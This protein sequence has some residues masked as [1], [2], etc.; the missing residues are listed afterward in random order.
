MGKMKLGTKI[1]GMVA[2]LL[3]LMVVSSSFGIIKIADVGNKIK[4]IA[5]EDIPLA[6]VMTGIATAQLKQDLLLE[7][8]MRYGNVIQ[9]NVNAGE[10]IGTALQK[11][12]EIAKK[13]DEEIRKGEQ[14]A[15]QAAK[16]ARTAAA[17]SEFEGILL[18]LRDIEKQHAE[19]ESDGLKMFE[20]IH[21]GKLDE[22]GALA[23]VLA[24]RVEKLDN[25]LD[26]ALRKI[27]KFTATAALAAEHDEVSG[28]RGMSIISII[29]IALGLVLGIF[30]T[31]SITK[32]INRIIESLRD[33]AGQVASA[34]TQ[35][36][37]ASQ[38]LAE[39]A[40]EQAASI[41][42][43]SSSLEEISSMTKQNADNANQANS[44]TQN[45]A[46]VI[47][48]ANESMGRLTT[49]MDEISAA[50]G[51]T[52]K[53]IKTIDEIAFQTNLLALN[54]AVE[55]ARAGEAGAGFAVVAGEVRNLA[56]RAADAAKGTASL[57]EG[58]VGK[59][60]AGSELVRETNEAFTEVA[61]KS[62]KTGELVAEI[63][64]ASNEQAE[65]IGQ[66]NK[67]I[68]EMDKVTQQNAAN[69]EESAS[70][71]EQ[72]SAQAEQMKGVVADLAALVGGNGKRTHNGRLST[73]NKET[74]RASS[75]KNLVAPSKT[76][77]EKHPALHASKE[78]KPTEVIPM[79]DGDFTDF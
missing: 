43:T 64:A 66:I 55:A 72:M 23:E 37:S 48:K 41:E 61:E 9:K 13:A 21:A 38:S 18:Q 25:E 34:S 6:N 11:F 32:P 73:P 57:I 58:T 59:V 47:T 56:M 74:G 3:I 17:R 5:E 69:A 27:E 49:S 67:A 10:Y 75:A 7:R 36:S 52:F 63:A 19:Y 8:A 60:H 45:T 4:G 53:I 76:A 44:I 70:A 2:V 16:D 20:L 15:G 35:V 62:S 12:T 22:A 77:K 14:I 71:S 68:N 78:I 29:A 79:D 40:S 42:E 50:S 46:A 33:G 24:A 54:A 39:G 30:I 1:V 51:E 26:P 65:G 28:K 31:R